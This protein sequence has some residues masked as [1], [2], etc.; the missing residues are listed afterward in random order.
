MDVLELVEE[1]LK[2]GAFSMHD[3][4]DVKRLA[5]ILKA[6]VRFRLVV[7]PLVRVTDG[8]Y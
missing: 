4:R 2:N 1:I 6:L 5:E 3:N 7:I 8:C